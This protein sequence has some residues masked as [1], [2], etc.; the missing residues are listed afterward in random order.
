MFWDQDIFIHS[1]L[2]IHWY[3]NVNVTDGK[4]LLFVS[5]LPINLPI[6]ILVLKKTYYSYR[7]DAYTNDDHIVLGQLLLS[8]K[9]TDTDAYLFTWLDLMLY[10]LNSH[11]LFRKLT[12]LPTKKL[13]Q[14]Y[15]NEKM[16]LQPF[17]NKTVKIFFDSII[18]TRRKIQFWLNL[19][20]IPYIELYQTSSILP[21]S[22]HNS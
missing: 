16:I 11:Q 12:S 17:R 1:F 19:W 18:I 13:K 9:W 6:K 7:N 8:P 2:S 3:F 20:L 22:R 5:Y 14:N 10:I 15:P 4:L 21:A